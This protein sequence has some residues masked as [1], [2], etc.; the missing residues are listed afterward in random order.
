[1]RCHDSGKTRADH[2]RLHNFSPGCRS[3]TAQSIISKLGTFPLPLEERLLSCR[4]LY[5]GLG[6][7]RFQP[8]SA[9]GS[10]LR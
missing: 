8:E 3:L 6:Q 5:L 1:M 9:P 4:Q 10:S 7:W 2:A